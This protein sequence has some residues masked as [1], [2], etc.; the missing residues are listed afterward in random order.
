MVSMASKRDYYEVLGV[1]KD[2]SP[3]QIKKA[4]KKLAI[5]NHPDRNPGD[6]AAVV[7]FKEAA[8]AF[9]VLS[10]DQKR[11][12]LRP[13]RPRRRLGQ[14]RAAVPRRLGHL[15]RVRR[16]VRKVSA[17]SARDSGAAAAPPRQPP[18]QL[19]HHRSAR[20]LQRLR[21]DSRNHPSGSVCHLPRQRRAA[22]HQA[23]D[24]RLLRRP[25]TGR[26]RAGVFP[27]ADHVSGLPGERASRP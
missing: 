7:R 14:R 10:D 25:R 15:R 16:S 11:A 20:S 23:T 9:E 2:A 24:L 1:Q 12:A 26:P 13:L 21:A 4:Y 19:D 22:R 6:E 5:A 3:D 17:C 18:P 27:R 8:E